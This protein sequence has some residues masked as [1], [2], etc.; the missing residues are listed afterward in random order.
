M[1]IRRFCNVF[2]KG[3]QF[4]AVLVQLLANGGNAPDEHARV[5]AEVALRQVGGGCFRIRFFLEAQN[6]TAGMGRRGAGRFLPAF[7]VSVGRARPSG[8]DAYGDEGFFLGGGVHGSLHQ[9][10]EVFPV[11]NELVGRDDEHDAGRRV[12]TDGFG[13]DV[14]R[15]DVRR[16]AAH[17]RF[18]QMVGEDEDV[19]PGDEAVQPVDGLAEQGVFPNDVEELL[20]AVVP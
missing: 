4:R 11:P 8:L 3:G 1:R 18:L 17:F 14:V 10:A 16:L 19:L 6:F 13:Y 20:G 12:T 7:N 2:H 9:G 5:P 15:G